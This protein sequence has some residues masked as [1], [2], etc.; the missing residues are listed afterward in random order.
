[1]PLRDALRL[2]HVGKL[3]GR[4][5]EQLQEPGAAAQLHHFTCNTHLTIRIDLQLQQRWP[6]QLIALQNGFSERQV[7]IVRQIPTA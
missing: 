5:H 7:D 3:H 4:I 1:M 2:F 6:T